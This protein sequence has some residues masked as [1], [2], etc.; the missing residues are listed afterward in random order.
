MV[1]KDDSIYIQDAVEAIGKI[2]SFLTDKAQESFVDDELTVSA[3]AYQAAIVGEALNKVS[4]EFQEK[5]DAIPWR[6]AI[7]NRNYLIHDYGALNPTMLWDTCTISMPSLKD[8]LVEALQD[9]DVNS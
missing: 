2:Q 5:N 6:K 9:S 8:Q 7:S 1:Q 4:S 3:V